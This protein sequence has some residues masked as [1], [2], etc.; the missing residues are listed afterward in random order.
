LIRPG[1]DMGDAAR[2][3]VVD[4]L[5]NLLD[6]YLLTRKDDLDNSKYNKTLERLL[7]CVKMDRV[8]KVLDRAE[9]VMENGRSGL[10]LFKYDYDDLFTAHLYSDP[11][12]M[13]F[14]EG[15]LMIGKNTLVVSI[16]EYSFMAFTCH[17]REFYVFESS[18]GDDDEGYFRVLI[19]VILRGKKSD[20]L[21]LA[22][23]TGSYKII[24]YEGPEVE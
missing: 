24:E 6:G 16:L 4:F 9:I 2:A 23:T 19:A 18:S 1:Y 7:S 20:E 15:K 11:G 8:K 10:K 14:S 17:D 3:V 21:Q 12:E 22:I 13:W 5:R